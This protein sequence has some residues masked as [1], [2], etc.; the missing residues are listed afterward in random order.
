MIFNFRK[1]VGAF[2]LVELLVTISLIILF[3]VGAVGYNRS[4]EFQISQYTEQGKII[5]IIEKAKSLAISTYNTTGSAGETPCGYGVYFPEDPSTH[6]VFEVILFKDLPEA[7]GSCPIY[8]D[9]TGQNIY[10][11]GEAVEIVKLN[12]VW[13]TSSNTQN[14][15][16][17]FVPPDPQIYTNASYFPLEINVNASRVSKGL[18]I[19]INNFG[20]TIY[21]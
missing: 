18:L 8:N 11:D 13:I 15:E 3:T 2:T 17:L 7:N 16:I 20:Q 6:K 19:K 12:N 21:E 9:N 1:N 14:L 5:N 4:T 10:D